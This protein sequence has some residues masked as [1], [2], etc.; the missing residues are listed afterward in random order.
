MT[1]LD[2]TSCRLPTSFWAKGWGQAFH[3][4]CGDPNPP[5]GRADPEE[6]RGITAIDRAGL[7]KTNYECYRRIRRIYQRLL[8]GAYP[9]ALFRWKAL[10]PHHSNTAA[11]EDA[12]RS[13]RM[14]SW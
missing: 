14:A 3:G 12:S 1:G 11:I 13:R 6:P 7:E 8:P 5:D 2:R 9:S 4:K 10:W